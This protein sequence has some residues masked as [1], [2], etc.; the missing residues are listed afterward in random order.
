MYACEDNDVLNCHRRNQDVIRSDLY[1]DVI[2][3]LRSDESIRNIGQPV[4]LALSHHG[5]DR[6]MI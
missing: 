1:R 6:H 2:D 4:I 5:G 3:M